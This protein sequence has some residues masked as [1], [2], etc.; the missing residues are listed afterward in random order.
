MKF[1]GSYIRSHARLYTRLRD[2]RSY[3]HGVT[4]FEKTFYWSKDLVILQIGLFAACHSTY[5][6]D[7]GSW[8]VFLV[9]CALQ[10]LAGQA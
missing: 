2:H 6:S 10:D 9:F 3:D 4:P 8:F 1:D 7:L 5:L